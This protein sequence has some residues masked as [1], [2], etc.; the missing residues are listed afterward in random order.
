MNGASSRLLSYSSRHAP[1]AS[2][3]SLSRISARSCQPR[4]A[5][6]SRAQRYWRNAGAVSVT[7]AGASA[8]VEVSTLTFL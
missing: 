3:E 8:S 1:T 2:Q 7:S 5:H 4:S 6:A